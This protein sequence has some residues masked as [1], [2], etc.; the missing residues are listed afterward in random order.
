MPTIKMTDTQKIVH[1][2]KTTEVISCC[3]PYEN[4]LRSCSRRWNGHTVKYCP[5]CG[6]KVIVDLKE[7]PPPGYKK[8]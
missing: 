6:E 8:A 3:S 1:D 7:I 2:I 4:F 5:F